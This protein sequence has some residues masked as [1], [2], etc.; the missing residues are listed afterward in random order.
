MDPSPAPRVGIV[1]PAGGTGRRLGGADKPGITL[2]G[3][4]ILDR[5]VADLPDWPVVVVGPHRADA[6]L[7]R[8]RWAREDPPL[9]GPAAALAAGV[10]ELPD[11]DV[12]VVLAGDLPFG[13]TA[14]R[15]LVDALA[16]APQAEAALGLD[17]AG[18]EQPLAAAYRRTALAERLAGDQDG[19]SL[20]SVTAGLV[21]VH[22]RLTAVEAVDVDDAASL[23]LARG[24][25]EGRGTVEAGTPRDHDVHPDGV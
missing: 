1:V 11:V 25:V 21:R 16:D 14:A 12:V 2:G 5:L 4:T 17:A 19:R 22:V 6:G 7:R 18:R 13:A 9:G 10:R 8:V 23:G 24:I 3:R 20:R 15:R